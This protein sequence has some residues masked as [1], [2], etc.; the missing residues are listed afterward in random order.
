MLRFSV[1]FFQKVPFRFAINIYTLQ[2]TYVTIERHVRM[3]F[4]VIIL[5]MCKSQ[6]VKNIIVYLCSHRLDYSERFLFSSIFFF[7][8]QFDLMNGI[9]HL[10]LFLIGF[11]FF[12]CVFVLQLHCEKFKAR[13]GKCGEPYYSH[14]STIYSTT[15]AMLFFATAISNIYLILKSI[16]NVF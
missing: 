12:F 9:C 1:Y 11:H 8:H 15:T 16:P 5:A 2:S 4:A 3:M 14:S 6:L 13:P 10:A 7:R